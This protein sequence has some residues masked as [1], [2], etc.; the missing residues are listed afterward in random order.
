MFNLQS[1]FQRSVLL[2]SEIRRSV[3]RR[4]LQKS[5]SVTAVLNRSVA[6]EIINFNL[7]IYLRSIIYLLFLINLALVEL[8]LKASMSMKWQVQQTSWPRRWPANDWIITNWKW[9]H[10]TKTMNIYVS[11]Y[12]YI[13]IYI[14]ICIY[15]IQTAIFKNNPTQWRQK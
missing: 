12:I 5:E 1:V 11:Y 14:Y 9:W 10:G 4:S 7:F 2:P 15:S 6:H 8:G 3:F 13:H